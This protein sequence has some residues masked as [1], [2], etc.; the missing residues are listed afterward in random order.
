MDY[1][2]FISVM[3][4]APS[5]KEINRTLAVCALRTF[6]NGSA[7]SYMNKTYQAIDENGKLIAFK[8]KTKCL[9]IESFDK[10]LYVT[11]DEKVY[12]LKEFEKI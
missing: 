2:K 6:D 3:E 5:E 9:V 10:I 1:N 12:L 7:I 4:I 11:V 8:P